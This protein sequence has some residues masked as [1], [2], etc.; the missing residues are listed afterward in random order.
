MPTEIRRSP[1]F[2][3]RVPEP[4]EIQQ[5]EQPGLLVEAINELADEFDSFL[6]KVGEE[7]LANEPWE[8]RQSFARLND[9]VQAMKIL[10]EQSTKA[11]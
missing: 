8:F 7:Q 2:I 1:G 6:R 11:G 3:E 9:R 5:T 4:G 10:I